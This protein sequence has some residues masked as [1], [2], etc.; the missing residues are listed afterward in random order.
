MSDRHKISEQSQ[1]KTLAKLRAK[2]GFETL[3][4]ILTSGESE[5]IF[6]NKLLHEINID[7]GNTGKIG[8]GLLHIIEGRYTRDKHN[9]DEIAAILYKVM[10]AAEY[11]NIT[12][13]VNIREKNNDKRVGIEK[14]GI[15][16]I[17]SKRQGTNENFVLTGYKINK[18][19][20]EATE[21]IRTVIAQY[22]NTPEFSDFR[23]QVGAV[24]SS[25]QISHKSIEKSREIEAARKAGYVQGVCEC[26]VA[27]GDDHVLGKKLLTEMNVNKDMAK[28]FANPETFKKLEQGIF[29]P[30]PEQIQ[31][32]TQ[33][34]KR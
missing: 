18:K 29:E 9:Q 13:S 11:G 1:L 6:N 10:D 14:D 5:K 4:N 23:K 28:K 21:A 34:I 27:I 33:N 20:E 31:E 24:V 22:G 26:V 16:A 32:Q 3:T 2:N 7:K 17:V 30:K 19:K 25:I 8:Y 12:D 15:I